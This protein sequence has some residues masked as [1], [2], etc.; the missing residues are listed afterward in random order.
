MVFITPGVDFLAKGLVILAAF[1]GAIITFNLSVAART[2]LFIPTWMLLAG[3]AIAIPLLLTVSIMT[4]KILNSRQAA[5]MGAR[6]VPEV[7]GMWLGNLD[8]LKKMIG[9]LEVGYP[10]TV[11][12]MCQ[13]PGPL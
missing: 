8:I 7:Q 2:G 11:P 12:S 6:V 13:L 5:A 10:G 4:Q 9:N 3:T 1:V